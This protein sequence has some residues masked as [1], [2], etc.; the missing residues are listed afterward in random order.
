MELAVAGIAGLVLAGGE[1]RRIGGSKALVPLG[2]KLL[3]QHVVERLAPQVETLWLSVGRAPGAL[4][5]LG[6]GMVTDDAPDTAGPLAGIV[7]GLRHASAAGYALL[8]VVPCD[9]PFLPGDLVTVLA[10]G[11]G[12][13]GLAVI[14]DEHVHPTFSLWR[15]STLAAAEVA[16]A[17]GRR[18]LRS[19]CI[20]LGAAEVGAPAH[21]PASALFNVNTREDLVEASTAAV[22]REASS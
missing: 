11:L 4:A 1:G 7:A 9:A 15:T 10:G 3:V 19:L 16:L 12:E 6:Y 18:R 22:T 8:A 14:V 21:W 5:G 2:G 17:A 13:A 20:E